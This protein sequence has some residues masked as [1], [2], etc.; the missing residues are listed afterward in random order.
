M[1]NDFDLASYHYLENNSSYYTHKILHSC[2]DV[3]NFTTCMLN[4]EDFSAWDSSPFD[5]NFNTFSLLK[6]ILYY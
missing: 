1:L 2:C 4:Y 6:L 3:C 5:T